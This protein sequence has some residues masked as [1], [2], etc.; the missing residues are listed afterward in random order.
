[1]LNT[2]RIAVRT[3]LLTLLVTG[4][5]YP[6]GMTL[7]AQWVFPSRAHGSLVTD[8]KGRVVGSGLIGQRFR[9]PT[10]FQPRPSAAGAQGYDAAASSGS[11]LGPS[12][13]KLRA[14]VELEL[15]RL[16]QDN[17]QSSSAI[18][19]D[20]VTASA[21]GLD[22]HLSVQAA[23][24]QVSRVAR[25]RGITA[26]RVRIVV[27]DHVEGREL[28]LIGEPRVNVLL[29][30][31]AMDRQFGQPTGEAQPSKQTGVTN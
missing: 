15:L 6:L 16:L 18:P 21:S 8:G 22:P 30:N 11:N 24:W 20:L 1:M 10:Y 25:A 7:L 23:L 31:L 2:I 12:S 26:E 28:G 29:L 4:L 5:L 17:P 14:R 3:T 19:G 9:S 13:L 27:L